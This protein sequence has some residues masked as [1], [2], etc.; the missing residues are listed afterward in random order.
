MLHRLNQVEYQFS[1]LLLWYWVDVVGPSVYQ[2]GNQLAGVRAYPNAASAL[3]RNTVSS[4]CP[5]LSHGPL[6]MEGNWLD[7]CSKTR[8]ASQQPWSYYCIS[9]TST[10]KGLT[11]RDLL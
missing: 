4:I 3:S 11:V 2:I 6:A 9:G 1:R 5:P 7:H 8:H 10:L